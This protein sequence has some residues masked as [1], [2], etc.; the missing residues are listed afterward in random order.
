M[1]YNIT[2]KQLEAFVTIAK[3]GSFAGACEQLHISQPALSISIKNLEE[4]IGGK[5]FYR[6]TR[7]IELTPEGRKFLAQAQ[8]ALIDTEAA[9]DD[10]RNHFLL[11]K[12]SLNIAVMPSFAA[13][14]L[15]KY[16]AVFHKRY[17]NINIKV[18]DIVAEDA[19]EMVRAG[20]AD[21]AITFDP[22]EH[23]DLKFHSFVEDQF[24][25][26]IPADSLLKEHQ[27]IDL[28]VLSNYPFIAL[29]KP[30]SIRYLIEDAL[31]RD[32]LA[33]NIEIEVNQ[34]LTIVKLVSQGMGV[35][36][37]PQLFAK[38]F[39]EPGVK[40]IPLTHP[41]ISRSIGLVTHKRKTISA[42]ASKFINMINELK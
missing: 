31:V 22:G 7:A 29:Q 36:I 1:K 3:E 5:L 34:L 23:D 8:R 39:A 41:N 35:S 12:G 32:D 17:P 9:I 11:S 16:L 30:S 26:A 24:I 19:I 10:V 21:L 40:F 14:N 28:K 38:E 6:T 20:R 42:A 18:S 2:L 4:S 33:L 37:I 13:A 25:A 15:S 27:E